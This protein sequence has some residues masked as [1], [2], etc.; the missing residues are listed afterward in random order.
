M[1]DVTDQTKV[2]DYILSRNGQVYGTNEPAYRGFPTR[3]R[4]LLSR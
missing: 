2:I 3:I 4:G 1:S